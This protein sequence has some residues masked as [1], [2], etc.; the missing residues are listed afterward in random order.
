MTG[1]LNI[2]FNTT[3]IEERLK[4]KNKKSQNK[5]MKI[6][7]E[8]LFNKRMTMLNNKP[9][10][11]RGDYNSQLDVIITNR[12]H[13]INNTKT[14]TNLDSDRD[15]IV[16]VRKLYRNTKSKEMWRNWHE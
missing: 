11:H 14:I 4:I 1:D 6:M 16:T 8:K 5:L 12:P 3:N 9:T 2:D 10:F 7:K 13:K 15:A